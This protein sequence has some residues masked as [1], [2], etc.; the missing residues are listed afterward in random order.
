[1]NSVS[2]KYRVL[3]TGVTGQTGSY[4]ADLLINQGHEVHGLVRRASSFSRSRIEHLRCDPNVYGNSLF[5]HYADLS[6]A[7]AIRRIIESISPH[8]IYHLAGQSHVGLSFEIPESTM[9]EV[10]VA[11][12][13]ILEIVRDLSDPPRVFHASSAEV[14]GDALTCPQNE[15]VA[16]RP[17]NP[18][19]CSKV[20]ATQILQVYR[21]SFGLFMCNGILYNHESPRRSENFVTRK[22]TQ[23]AARL[24]LGSSEIL[25]LG[26]I[27]AC[28]D[29]GYAPEYADFMVC[30]LRHDE[31]GDY[32]VSTGT[33]T[34]VR[35]FA[36]E[37][38]RSLGIDI[39][40]EGFGLNEVG[41]DKRSGKIILEIDSKYY[42]PVESCNLVGDSSKACSILGWRPS[43]VGCDIAGIMAKADFEMEVNKLA[44]S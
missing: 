25:R 39:C 26:N 37:S 1:M 38:F 14:F 29:W 31:P 32:V 23:A 4:L 30:S 2:K 7:T 34:S 10:A 28:R 17:V 20:F 5:L 24:A 16:F 36:K 19:G 27:D 41:F 22:I 40:F 44:N 3:V 21:E 11:T 18:Y 33:L 9:R 15:N 43:V 6:D 8:E 42:R 12:L 35:D 13:S